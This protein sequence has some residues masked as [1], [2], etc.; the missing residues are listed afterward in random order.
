M[1]MMIPATVEKEK[2]DRMTG[3]NRLSCC[4]NNSTYSRKYTSSDR[5]YCML[6]KG[7]DFV[8]ALTIHFVADIYSSQ[9]TLIC[10]IF[11]TIT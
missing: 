1:P 10:L 6:G 8:R 11:S 7:K 5:S 4:V 9:Y 3:R 2:R